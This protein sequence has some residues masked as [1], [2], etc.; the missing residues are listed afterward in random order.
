MN[1]CDCGATSVDLEENYMKTTGEPIVI[2]EKV[3][4][5]NKWSRVK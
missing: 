1:T 3:F 5:N 4:E 2:S